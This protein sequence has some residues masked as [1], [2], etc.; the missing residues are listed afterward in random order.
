MRSLYVLLAHH[1]VVH[2]GVY[3]RMAQ[4]FLHLLDGHS[5][6]NG[7]SGERAAELVRMHSTDAGCFAEV[8]QSQLYAA[9]GD[10][11]G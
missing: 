3:F 11:P 2:G 6:V 9:D 1:G 5:L 10:A 8:A 4:Q 7:M